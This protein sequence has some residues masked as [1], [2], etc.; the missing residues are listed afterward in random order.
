MASSAAD[1]GV[2]RP[3]T[4]L[5][6]CNCPPRFDALRLRSSERTVAEHSGGGD[7]RREGA[8]SLR[9][10]LLQRKRCRVR[11]RRCSPRGHR[12]RPGSSPPGP[13]AGTTSGRARLSS[14]R[15]RGL[16]IL[17]DYDSDDDDDA[18]ACAGWESLCGRGELRSCTFFGNC[19]LYEEKFRRDPA[20][21]LRLFE[22]GCERGERTACRELGYLYRNGKLVPKDLARAYALQSRAC[23]MD[24]PAACASVAQ[25]LD[26]VGG[27]PRD[28]EKAKAL[29]R[30][31]CARGIRPYPCEALRRMGEQPP[32][33]TVSFGGASESLFESKTYAYGWRTPA[34]WQFVPPATLGWMATSFGEELVAARPR[35]GNSPDSL[36]IAVTD[37]IELGFED[38]ELPRPDQA[39]LDRLQADAEQSMK[40]AGFTKTGTSMTSFFGQQ[41]TRIDGKA[42]GT[43]PRF[44]TLVL[45]GKDRRR[46]E[47]RCLTG[48]PQRGMPCRAAFGSL[49]FHDMPGMNPAALEPRDLHVRDDRLSVAFDPP[50]GGWYGVGPRLAANGGQAVWTW[51]FADRR[52]DLS[53]Q[54]LLQASRALDAESA[55]TQ[56]ADDRRKRGAT[57]ATDASELAGHPCVHV[58]I[59]RPKQHPQDLYFVRHR[60]VLYVLSITAEGRDQALLRRVRAGLHFQDPRP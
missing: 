45:F 28:L 24:D 8:R 59:D 29:Y 4:Q 54:D 7:L 27:V 47:A 51:K 53:A 9:S 46:F 11:Y 41:A 18:I 26:W 25:L 39:A 5:G 57:V 3:R 40:A 44:L 34:N 33:S 50:D 22:E 55:A 48:L 23:E 52:I 56:F 16:P 12:R 31:S 15:P 36:T 2:G 35:E 10:G 21:A 20:R 6:S 19:L 42:N 60:D 38:Y 30:M 43:G 49:E 37:A 14:R 17:V 1:G 13:P 32:S 58:S